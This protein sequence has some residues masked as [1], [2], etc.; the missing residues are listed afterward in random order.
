M[1]K[2]HLRVQPIIANSFPR[3]INFH[4]DDVINDHLFTHS[5]VEYS[6]IEIQQQVLMDFEHLAINER[7]SYDWLTYQY[8]NLSST[9]NIGSL[10]NFIAK[11]Y[12]YRIV[13]KYS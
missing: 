8:D 6:K 13:C 12:L 5:I 9:P 4:L 2:K 7:L 3:D 11:K 10:N 1:Y